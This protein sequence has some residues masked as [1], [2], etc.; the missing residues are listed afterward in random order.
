MIFED[1]AVA[2]IDILGFKKIVTSACSDQNSKEKLDSLISLLE[3]V[4]PEIDSH[5]SSTVPKHLIPDHIYISDSIILSAPLSD[6]SMQNYDGLSIIVMRCIQLTHRLLNEGYLVRG[7]I[8]IG[9]T[10]HTKSN[11]VGI[12]YQEAFELEKDHCNPNIL[13]SSKA[14]SHWKNSWSANSRMCVFKDDEFIV[15][16]LH[17]Y[18]VPDQSDN[19]IAEAYT[20][21]KSIISNHLSSD[22]DEKYKVKWRWFKDYLDG[23]ELHK[24]SGFCSMSS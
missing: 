21:Y 13:L 16:G 11:I 19:G 15:N 14:R 4:V 18:Y 8:S 12:A 24:W 17:D 1:R 10:W 20:H 6:T 7:G 2:F 9:K 3:S 22:L 5:V 23:E